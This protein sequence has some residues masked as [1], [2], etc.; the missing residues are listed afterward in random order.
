M[1]DI[2]VPY[3]QACIASSKMHIKS[4]KKAIKSLEDLLESSND[5]SI[6]IA[7]LCCSL[8]E[9]YIK[10]RLPVDCLSVTANMDKLTTN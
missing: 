10:K 2:K 5:E 8:L 4:I 6:K 1:N 7:Y 3:R 9:L